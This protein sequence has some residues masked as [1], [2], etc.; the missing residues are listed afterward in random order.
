MEL[1]KLSESILNRPV[2]AVVT[3]YPHLPCLCERDI[4]DALEYIGVEALFDRSLH[5]QP[6]ELS[7]AYAGYGFGLCKDYRHE[8]RCRDQERDLPQ[9]QVLGVEYTKKSLITRLESITTAYISYEPA[10][11][12]L[13]D[14]G[15]GLEHASNY[16][17]GAHVYW[18]RV[19]LRLIQLPL[20]SW[21]RK[22]IT[23]V[24][25]IGESASNGTF[26]D[27][28]RDAM[29]KLQDDPPQIYHK[30]SLFVA[31][32]GAADFATRAQANRAKWISQGGIPE[33]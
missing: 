13:I 16:P 9:E 25:L 14:T 3:S 4:S 23:K 19:R 17:G 24:L 22:N 30:D 27:V 10:D 29:A 15:S 26:M 28:V 7:A 6:H 2:V 32:R 20:E 1:R 33:L 18:D 11:T 31:A 5:Y 8:G 12:F 21:S